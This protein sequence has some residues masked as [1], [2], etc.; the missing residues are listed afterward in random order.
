MMGGREPILHF[1]D[2]KSVPLQ[3]FKTVKQEENLNFPQASI[4][5]LFDPFLSLQAC[6]R[7]PDLLRT[8]RL[9]SCKNRLAQPS[10][11]SEKSQAMIDIPWVC[12][13]PT[14][15]CS[16]LPTVLPN[17]K[18]QDTPRKTYPCLSAHQSLLLPKIH[19]DIEICACLDI[20][21]VYRIK[22]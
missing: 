14:F 8:L 22:G 13:L 9:Q 2:C 19:E 16:D 18:Y 21:V 1:M 20:R 7:K 11:R 5:A 12:P 17:T 10:W 6:I 15:L 3:I 4:S